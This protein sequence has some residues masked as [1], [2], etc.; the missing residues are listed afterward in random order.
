MSKIPSPHFQ[1]ES[2]F[3]L[4]FDNFFF[5]YFF[6]TQDIYFFL[7]IYLFFLTN[8]TKTKTHTHTHS[9]KKKDKR[10]QDEITR[11]RPTPFSFWMEYQSII[12]SMGCHFFNNLS[13]LEL[14][15]SFSISLIFL[16]VIIKLLKFNC[17]LFLVL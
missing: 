8:K 12:W 9:H 1:I 10:K 14:V 2:F 4:L 17:L 11:S 5:Y 7:F 6:L 3:N 16:I 13:L 15:N